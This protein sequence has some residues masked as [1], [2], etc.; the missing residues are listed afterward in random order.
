MT[1]KIPSHIASTL[2]NDKC[3][4]VIALMMVLKFFKFF[5]FG[6][7][8]YEY[9]IRAHTRRRYVFIALSHLAYALLAL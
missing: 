4:G 1:S 8:S 2:A 3:A 9:L 5:A 7:Y 6:E